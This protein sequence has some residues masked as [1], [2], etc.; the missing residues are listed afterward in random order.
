MRGADSAQCAVVGLHQLGQWPRAGGTDRGVG[1]IVQRR[2]AHSA[3]SSSR[4]A[5]LWKPEGQILV[6]CGHAAEGLKLNP[7]P[8]LNTREL[9]KKPR[10]ARPEQSDVRNA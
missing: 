10:I 3:V 1:D 8:R 7:G 4:L 5:T 9:P 2:R 6:A